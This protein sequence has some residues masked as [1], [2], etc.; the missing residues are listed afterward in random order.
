MTTASGI[1]LSSE[2]TNQLRYK[3][4]LVVAVGTTVSDILEGDTIYYDKS[5]SYTMLINNEQYTVIGER[6]V[7]VVTNR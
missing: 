1:L 5:H 7:M 2:D 4:G 6:D 3:E